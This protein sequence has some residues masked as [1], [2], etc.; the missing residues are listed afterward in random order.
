[1]KE[2]VAV[3]TSPPATSEGDTILQLSK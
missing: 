3:D 1:V 2:N